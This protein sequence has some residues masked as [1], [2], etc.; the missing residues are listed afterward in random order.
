[1]K[2][3][4]DLS[5]PFWYEWIEDGYKD[6][7]MKREAIQEVVGEVNQLSSLYDGGGALIIMSIKRYHVYKAIGIIELRNDGTESF[8]NM[9]EITVKEM[10]DNDI[11]IMI[12]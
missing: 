5:S 9:F 10:P 4:I 12:I 2:S 11:E 7:D 3:G 8:N 1:M 6:E